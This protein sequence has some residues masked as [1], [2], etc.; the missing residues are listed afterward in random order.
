MRLDPKMCVFD[1]TSRK[2]LEQLISAIRIEAN[3]YKI[4]VLASMKPFNDFK[5]IQ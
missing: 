1:I 5:E 3:P 4:E 2:F